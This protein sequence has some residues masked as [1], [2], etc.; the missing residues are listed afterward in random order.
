ME[1]LINIINV[2]KNSGKE[3]D[4]DFCQI[5]PIN[6]M[7]R[8]FRTDIKCKT[9]SK[10]GK[11]LT[12]P[13]YSP[14]FNYFTKLYASYSFAVI[15]G[16]KWLYNNI[17]DFN[18]CRVQSSVDLLNVLLQIETLANSYGFYWAVSF[19]AGSCKLCKVC[20]VSNKVCKNPDRSRYP[21]EATGVDVLKTCKNI[22][23]NIGDFP[24]IC[25]DS[26]HFWRI[27]LVL[28]Q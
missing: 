15:L 25:K 21:L 22:G 7:V 9:C 27:G 19:G 13:P 10:Y 17:E 5:L 1:S 26:G 28:L 12:C 16:K 3:H 20:D 18:V 4:L 14:D 8:D 6:S 2:I 23:I 11:N 24:H